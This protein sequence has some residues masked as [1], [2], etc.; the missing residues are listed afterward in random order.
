[1]ASETDAVKEARYSY[2][3]FLLALKIESASNVFGVLVI[4]VAFYILFDQLNLRPWFAVSAIVY[5][6]GAIAAVAAYLLVARARERLASVAPSADPIGP[7]EERTRTIA[8]I[9]AFVSM[10]LF[11]IGSSLPIAGWFWV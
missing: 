2:D 5:V 7:A 11:G 9:L 4:A 3:Q 6:L 1:M 8:A 10:S